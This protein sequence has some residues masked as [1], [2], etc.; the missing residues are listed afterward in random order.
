M[1]ERVLSRRVVLK[2]GIGAG[3]ASLLAACTTSAPSAPPAATVAPA[4]PG[5]A[6]ASGA[7]NAS[8][9]APAAAGQ[10]KHG[11]TLTIAAAG[12]PPDLDPFSSGSEAAALFASY[13][14]SRLFML[15]S[16]PG[17]SKGSLDTV[18]DAAES[19]TVSSDGLTYTIKLRNNVR[20][21]APLDRAMT[22]DDVVFSWE[23]FSGKTPGSTPS[24]RLVNLTMV[25]S[26]KAADPQTVVWTLKEP[27]PFF[28]ARLADPKTFFI[29][30]KETGTAFDPSQ[31]VVGSG[32]WV[33]Q[34]YQPNTVIKFSRHTGWHLGPDLPYFDNIVVN[35]IP[36]YATQLSQ[37]QAGNLDTVN[38]AGTDL[39]TIKDSVPGVQIYA[40]APYPLSVLNFSPLDK[41]WD[42]VRLRRAVSMAMDRSAMLDA[43]YGLQQVQQAGIQVAH[44]WHNYV[45]VSF[46]D[47]WLDPQGSEMNAEAA[48]N[49]KYDPATAKQL[50]DAAGGAFDTEFHYAAQNSGYGEPYRIISELFVQ[51]L[52]KVGINAKAFEED[53]NS[54]FLL[55]SSQGKTN[56]LTWIPQTRTDP[57]AYYQTQYL[58]PTH[59]IYGRWVDDQ[60]ASEVKQ[61]QG[62]TDPAQ[63]KS[64][65]R[66][67][68]N[69]LGSKMYVVPMQYGAAPTFIA[70]Q[71]YVQ[72][73][74]DYQTLAQ[75]GPAETIPH[76]WSNK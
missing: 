72:N 39:N 73:A 32:P 19:A 35:I 18:G 54:T 44:A 75:G 36:T 38:V 45:P 52:S 41:R 47:Y 56:G 5:A 59:P 48:A 26:V 61:I 74:L 14:Y 66:N 65:I 68:Q 9:S 71:A 33:L 57:F 31:K 3:I 1:T 70:Y 30:P 37:F 7:S 25:T 42:D 6:G 23:R 49:F 10:P 34:D 43:A 27:Y 15:K 64:Q 46:S 40:T 13:V 11:G 17:I 63:L 53:Y 22:A 16:G 62:L 69:E 29:M 50:V 2:L 4:A 12:N 67:L 8:T 60:L 55:Q 20:W 76:L 58:N 21:H 24:T 51:Y 28:L